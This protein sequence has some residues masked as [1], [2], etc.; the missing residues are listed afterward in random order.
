MVYIIAFFILIIISAVLLHGARS[1]TKNKDVGGV[2][3]RSYLWGIVSL[4]LSVFLLIEF[5][6]SLYK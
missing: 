3:F 5:V 1:M 6:K 2:I 4:L